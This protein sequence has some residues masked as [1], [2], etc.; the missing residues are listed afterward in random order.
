MS[1]FVYR[2]ILRDANVRFVHAVSTDLANEAVRR[3]NCDPLSSHVLCRALGA[4]VM[5]IPL[6]NPDE[7]Y[8]L[9]WN[10]AGAVRSV[11]VEACG[12][13]RVRGFI[14]PPDLYDYVENEQQIHGDSGTVTVVKG[15]ADR[16]L[17]TGTGQAGLLDVV[18]DLAFFFSVSDQVET[19]MA[20]MVG[21]RPDPAAPV[22]LCQGLMI[23]ALPDCDLELF[24]RLR[25]RLGEPECRA[26]LTAE[27]KIDNHFERLVQTLVADDIPPIFSLDEG[28]L[29]HFSCNCSHERMREMLK[30]VGREEL[31]Q[32]ATAG[33]TLKL[34]CHFCSSRYEM[35]PA[36]IQQALTDLDE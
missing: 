10:Y 32:A 22:C 13:G 29:P 16:T 26:L 33:E 19:G 23:Q 1:D 30:A 36:D 11:V 7:R 6:L 24:E 25:Q 28:P 14:T 31:Q 17:N 18:D 2:G 12:D 21:F 9:R 4:G 8:T 15:T 5:T 35:T 3:H 34:T 20:V 27:P